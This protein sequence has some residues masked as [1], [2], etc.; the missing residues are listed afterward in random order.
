MSLK[1]EIL[2]KVDTLDNNDDDISTEELSLDDEERKF[3]DGIET[4]SDSE[5]KVLL[6]F[7]YIVDINGNKEITF[8]L[9]TKKELDRGL[10][11]GLTQNDEI[12]DAYFLGNNVSKNKNIFFKENIIEANGKKYEY[13]DLR[14]HMTPDGAYIVSKEDNDLITRLDDDAYQMFSSVIGKNSDNTCVISVINSKIC[15]CC[16]SDGEVLWAQPINIGKN[17]FNEETGN[18]KTK[19]G[20]FH[21]SECYLRACIKNIYL[22]IDIEEPPSTLIIG[23]V[24]NPFYKIEN[25]NIQC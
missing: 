3:I 21:L 7:G 13:N 25:N 1:K 11:A 9:G 10:I 16:L 23:S 18:I 5:L 17:K 24:D 2:N 14:I 4:E 8:E 22:H 20:K 19:S 12:V 15:A 6:K